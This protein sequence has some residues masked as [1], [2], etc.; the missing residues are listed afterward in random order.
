MTA[1][2]KRETLIQE[3]LKLV[4]K[5]YKY[6]AYLEQNDDEPEAFDCSS[7]TRHLYKKIGIGIPRSSIL[8]AVGSQK[9]RERDCDD[10]LRFYKTKEFAPEAGDL[11]FI[12]GNKGHYNDE[13][14]P[15]ERVYIGHVMMYLGNGK[16]IHA[17]FPDG[18]IVQNLADI[19]WP[20]IMIKRFI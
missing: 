19:R 14:F 1:E 17:K 8:Q 10:F 12:R 9:P 4:G 5:P 15:G 2:E 16:V 11:L 7:F 20:I 13:L 18:V 6:G 3:A